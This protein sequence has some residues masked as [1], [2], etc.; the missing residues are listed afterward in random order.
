MK[1]LSVLFLVLAN[2]LWGQD[3]T[4]TKLHHYKM[5]LKPSLKIHYI[6][7]EVIDVPEN[8][9]LKKQ[10]L[11]PN[12]PLTIG[13]SG[14]IYN[15]Y[16][17]LGYSKS[18]MPFRS[19]S[20][21][22]KSKYFDFQLHSFLKKRFLFDLYYQDYKGFYYEGKKHTHI[23]SD[24]QIQQI[25]S[26]LLYFTHWKSQLLEKMFNPDGN[27]LK[28][29][30]GFYVGGG[31]YYHK[32]TIP[33][34]SLKDDGNV[35]RHLQAGFGV[36]AVGSM[37]ASENISV[38]GLIGLGGYFGGE[39]KPLSKMKFDDYLTYRIHLSIVHSKKDWIFIYS[40]GQN[41]K[42]MYFKNNEH[43]SIGTSNFEISCIR[44]FHFSTRYHNK[45]MKYLGM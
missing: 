14:G 44:Q 42:Q 34:L 12:Y 22:G 43:L 19:T 16:V 1:Y 11:L 23:L 3:S 37:K 21:Y 9:D 35:F 17:S 31:I 30:Y 13:I 15:T 6:S 8:E 40:W 7:V 25:G 10:K 32:A 45:V 24:T 33:I 28:D 27:H 5:W 18:T 38:N 36:G 26:E 39:L 29:H 41:N 20:E 2:S 4:Q